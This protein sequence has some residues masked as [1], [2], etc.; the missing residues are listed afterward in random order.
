MKNLLMTSIAIF[1][2]VT[3]SF[4]QTL[5]SYVP[6][7]GLVGWWPFNG[8]ANDESGNGN[9]GIV[10]DAILT[11]DRNNS[12]NSAYSFDGASSIV[13]D[14][15]SFTFV[16]NQDFSVSCYAYVTPQ[17]IS[18]P[19]VSYG[20]VAPDNFEWYLGLF[21]PN[22]EWGVHRGQYSWSQIQIPTSSAYPDLNSWY[23]IVGV[24]IN[25]VLN[26]YINGL[27]VGSVN[28][29]IQGALTTNLPLSFGWFTGTAQ[30]MHGKLDDIGIWNRALTE[31]EITS[32]H[33]GSSLGINELSLNNS[34]SVFPNPAQSVIN[35]NIEANLVGSVFTIY[36]ITGKAVKTGKLNSS[37]T[38]I[39]VNDLS[40]GIYSFSV[41]GNRKK[42]FKVIKE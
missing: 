1:G 23:H 9:E 6:T 5:P 2:L 17:S 33:F 39:E 3:I 8:N 29:E 32:L 22:M 12:L 25:G 35:V 13:V 14:T 41:G 34:F 15:P 20:N 42:T 18:D 31:E 21:N 26:L 40:G 7:D 38:T 36:D 27:L 24:K 28:Q 11:T 16:E 37:N 30:Y 4:G 19:F 10:N